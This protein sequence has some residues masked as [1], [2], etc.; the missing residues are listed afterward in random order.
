MQQEYL[1]NLLMQAPHANEQHDVHL[2]SVTVAMP[3]LRSDRTCQ[4]ERLRHAL[5]SRFS[6][7]NSVSSIQ[8]SRTKNLT[9]CWRRLSHDRRV[10]VVSLSTHVSADCS[11]HVPRKPVAT[12]KKCLLG[13]CE[14]LLHANHRC[15][16]GQLTER[17]LH[18]SECVKR[19]MGSGCD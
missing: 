11:R 17:R 6:L 10:S 3:L 12:V 5:I 1:N 18:G 8:S 16:C 9:Y 7:C 14:T 4:K 13:G 15:L 2:L 19:C